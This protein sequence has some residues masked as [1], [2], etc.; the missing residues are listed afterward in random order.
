M[1]REQ[2]ED[3]AIKALGWLASEPEQLQHFCNSTGASPDDILKR[4]QEP[5]FL[6]FVLDFLLLDDSTI[7][8]F[9]GEAE[10]QPESVQTARYALEGGMPQSM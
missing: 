1:N 8:T 6:G 10:I 2:A 7:L 3:I 4:A 5:E 9:A